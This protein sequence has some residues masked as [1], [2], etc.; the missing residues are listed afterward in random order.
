MRKDCNGVFIC[1]GML[2]HSYL[3]KHNEILLLMH[4]TTVSSI[5]IEIQTHKTLC[6]KQRMWQFLEE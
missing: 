6:R 4:G 5:A 2:R 3:T 1:C